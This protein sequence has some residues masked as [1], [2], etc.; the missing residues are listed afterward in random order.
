MST[1]IV[2][3]NGMYAVV[4]HGEYVDVASTYHD[5]EVIVASMDEAE[6]SWMMSGMDMLTDEVPQ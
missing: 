4:R 2:Y 3:M 6:Y 1:E 5:A